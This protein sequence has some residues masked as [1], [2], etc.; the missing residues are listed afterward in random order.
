M[1]SELS[2]T[3]RNSFSSGLVLRL[4]ETRRDHYSAFQQTLFVDKSVGFLFNF[5][6]L[7]WLGVTFRISSENKTKSHHVFSSDKQ[8][9]LIFQFPRGRSPFQKQILSNILNRLV[10]TERWRSRQNFLPFPALLIRLSGTGLRWLD[11]TPDRW[12]FCIA[13]RCPAS[14]KQFNCSSIRMSEFKHECFEGNNWRGFNPRVFVMLMLKPEHNRFNNKQITLIIPSAKQ[15]Y[16]MSRPPKQHNH[17]TCRSNRFRRSRGR[18]S[19][20]GNR[21]RKRRWR[22]LIAL[23]SRPAVKFVDCRALFVESN[24]FRTDLIYRTFDGCTCRMDHAYDNGSSGRCA[25]NA[26]VANQK[27]DWRAFRWHVLIEEFN[28]VWQCISSDKSDTIISQNKSRRDLSKAFTKSNSTNF[29][30]NF[31]NS[32]V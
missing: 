31:A 27:W 14:R 8:Q 21:I 25:A 17:L 19:H 12:T 22:V 2:E 9:S 3:E 16:R 13:S 26:T 30:A 15:T 23:S 11:F 32:H 20:S 6:G 4:I 10:S 18:L 7:H 1:G 24:Q 5:S 29:I 28:F